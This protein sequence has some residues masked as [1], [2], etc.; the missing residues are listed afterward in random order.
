MG[1]T[2][3]PHLTDASADPDPKEPQFAFA[4]FDV[5]DK[6]GSGTFADTY[7]AHKNGRVARK[8]LDRLRVS[9]LA[10]EVEEVIVLRIGIN[11]SFLSAGLGLRLELRDDFSLGTRDLVPSRP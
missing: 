10:R 5:F 3:P 8:I 9:P 1:K 6:L 4:G 7:R 2:Y 11:W